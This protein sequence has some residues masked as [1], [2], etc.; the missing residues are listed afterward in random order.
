MGRQIIFVV[1]T[2]SECKS[3]WIYI[4]DTLDRFYSYDRIKV[5]LTPVYM[6]GKGN[7]KRKAKEISR[8]ISQYAS[9]AKGNTSEVIYCFDCDDYDIK[10]DDKIFLENAEKYC[11]EQCAD[12][13]WFCKDIERVYLGREVPAC[14]KKAEAAAFKAKKAINSVEVSRLEG[15]DY[16]INMSNILNVLDKHFDRK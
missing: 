4:K 2:D 7:Y 16:K 8:L 11:R 1:E 9:S 14:K 10:T 5:K 15:N 12:F 3:D 6:R 13:V